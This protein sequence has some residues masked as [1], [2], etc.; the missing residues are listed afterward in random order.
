[1]QRIL[2]HHIR[3]GD[4]VD[5]REIHVLAREFGEP[6]AHNGFVVVLFAHRMGAY[7]RIIETAR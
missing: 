2:Q 5:D 7:R 4:L 1:V 3:S 6:A